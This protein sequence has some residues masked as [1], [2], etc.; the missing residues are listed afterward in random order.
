MLNEH[1]CFVVNLLP[2]DADGAAESYHGPAESGYARLKVVDATME[3]MTD[4]NSR[5]RYSG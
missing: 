5:L 2:S 1:D 4:L 3:I